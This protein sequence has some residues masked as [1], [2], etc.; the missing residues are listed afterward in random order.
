MST[1]ITAEDMDYFKE[2]LNTKK[3]NDDKLKASALRRQAKELAR[4]YANRE[5]RL[6]YQRLYYH[7]NKASVD[8]PANL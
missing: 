7:K 5:K 2:W 8:V 3:D 1:Q 6:E 4:Y